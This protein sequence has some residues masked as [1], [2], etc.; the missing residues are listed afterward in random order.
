MKSKYEIFVLLELEQRGTALRVYTVTNKVADVK[1][2]LETEL[3]SAGTIA[4]V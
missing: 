1:V 2:K 4:R 3:F